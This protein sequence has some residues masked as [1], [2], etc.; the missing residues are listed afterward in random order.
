MNL[1]YELS[2]IFKMVLVTLL[3]G[4]IGFDRK[5]RK[6]PA[7]IKTH[8]IVGI[9]STTFTILALL[10]GLE[11]GDSNGSKIISAILSSMGFIGAGTIIKQDKENL[12]IGVTTAATLWLTSAIGI[13]VGMGYYAI[14]LIASIFS[15]VILKVLK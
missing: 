10:Y 1:E 8:I 6:K 15:F 2:V 9:A 11:K 5:K 14:A 4:L 13:A 12:V 7:G 3:A